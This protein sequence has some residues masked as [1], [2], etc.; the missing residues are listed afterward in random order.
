[1]YRIIEPE[2]A[3]GFGANTKM[4]TKVHPPIVETL[5]YEF[6]G[7]L[8]DDFLETFPC[9]IVSE[10]LK[11]Q[12]ISEKLTGIK[13][14]NVIISKSDNFEKLLPKIELPNFFWMKVDGKPNK[15]DFFIGADFR[16]VISENA[17]G[18]LKLFCIKHAL[19]EDYE[20]R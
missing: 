19:I 16:L 1:M 4:N 8:G 3:G 15:D 2:V 10:K 5:D 18:V 14:D 20:L 7:W 11:N 9:F 12:L 13:F 6:D 17:Y